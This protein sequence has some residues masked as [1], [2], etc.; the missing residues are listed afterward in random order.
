MIILLIRFLGALYHHNKRNALGERQMT[1][2]LTGLGW[3][4]F[5]AMRLGIK[6]LIENYQGLIDSGFVKSDYWE[7]EI[8]TLKT[9]LKRIDENR[10]Y[11]R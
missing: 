3:R 2:K 6:A 9:T 5:V 10:A 7:N 8:A 11:E 1:E 4:D